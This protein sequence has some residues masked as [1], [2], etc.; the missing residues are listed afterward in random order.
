MALLMGKPSRI[1]ISPLTPLESPAK[2]HATIEGDK[3]GSGSGSGIIEVVEGASTMADCGIIW[4]AGTSST[5]R[6]DMTVDPHI[7]MPK[8]ANAGQMEEDEQHAY[9]KQAL[10][11]P[12]LARLQADHGNSMVDAN[13]ISLEQQLEALYTVNPDISYSCMNE[14]YHKAAMKL[15]KMSAAPGLEEDSP[16]FVKAMMILMRSLM[17]IYC[18]TRRKAYREDPH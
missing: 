3:M 1:A 13:N 6:T 7:N 4:S 8:D 11:D 17:H 15:W 18:L 5:V 9:I 12:A 14:M 10:T 16:E 2:S